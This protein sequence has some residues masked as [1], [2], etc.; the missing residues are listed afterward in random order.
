MK[1]LNWKRPDWDDYFMFIAIMCATRHSYLK[2][3]VGAVIV[4]DKRIIAT[5]YNGAASGLK[6]CLQSGRCHY[7]QLALDETLKNGK[8][9]S[10]IREK[11]KGLYCSATHAETNAINQCSPKETREATL[12]ITN[13][14]CPKCTQD[15]IIARHFKT[16]KIWKEY[17][18]NPLLTIDEKRASERKLLEAGVS[19]AYVPLS[20]KRISEIANYMANKVGERTEYAFTPPTV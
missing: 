9:F 15:V 16:V 1:R 14:P 20:K 4:K 13:Y 11:F 3:G 2:R 7:E 18:S 5:G 19:V 10:E 12:Y 17:L 8:N 6:S